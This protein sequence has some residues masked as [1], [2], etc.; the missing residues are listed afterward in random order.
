VNFFTKEVHRPRQA[1]NQFVLL[2]SPLAPHIAEELWQLLGNKNTLAYEPWPK[3]DPAMLVLAEIEI[4]VQINGKVRGKISVPADLDAQGLE[5][6]ALQNEKIIE[7]VTGK[8]I[9]KKVIVPGRLVNFVI[10]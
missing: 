8:E 7:M 10:K 5:Q 3:F 4:P 9:V 1:M 6:A 2:L